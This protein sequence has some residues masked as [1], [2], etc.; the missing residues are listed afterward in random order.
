MAVAQVT[1]T[2][3][4]E[5]SG[6]GAGSEGLPPSSS[7]ESQPKAAPEKSTNESAA[8]AVVLAGPAVAH[9]LGG[10]LAPRARK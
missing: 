7:E 6:V 10:A 4:V 8:V 9:A 3:T 5:I 2:R 1:S